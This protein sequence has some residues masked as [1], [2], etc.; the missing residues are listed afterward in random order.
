MPPAG[1]RQNLGRKPIQVM[2]P[3]LFAPAAATRPPLPISHLS[4]VVS[5]GLAPVLTPAKIPLVLPQEKWRALVERPTI[6]SLFTP[7][8]VTALTLLAVK[9]APLDSLFLPPAAPIPGLAP[10]LTAVPL[11]VAPPVT[12]FI[13]SD[14]SRNVRVVIVRQLAPIWSP[15]LVPASKSIIRLVAATTPTLAT[16]V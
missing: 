12:I 7:K 4:V 9:A 10:A 5:P 1:Q 15:P 2:A 16:A 13:P 11:P 8:Q 14:R 6:K 3:P